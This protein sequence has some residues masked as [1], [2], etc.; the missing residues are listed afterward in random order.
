MATIKSI[1][2]KNFKVLR[3]CELPLSQFTLIIGPNGSGKST[4][5]ESV[6]A[7]LSKLDWDS[8]VAAGVR[9]QRDQCIEVVQEWG[10]LRDSVI[11]GRRWSANGEDHPISADTGGPNGVPRTRLEDKLARTRVFALDP[12]CLYQNVQLAPDQELEAD[13]TRLAGVVDRLRD[14]APDRFRL[15]NEEL[16]RWIP[17]FDHVLFSTPYPGK[18]CLALRTTVGHHKITAGDLSQGTLLALAI[19]TIASLADPPPILGLE[20]PNRGLHPRLLRD[21]RDAMYRLAYPDQYGDK[22]E[23]VQVIATTHSPYMVDLFRD[24]PEEIVI[25]QRVGDNVKFER[26]SDRPN[27]EE[28]IQDARL[29]DLWYT[30]VLGGVPAEP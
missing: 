14:E 20:E 4:A 9:G 28:I 18:R 16:H 21:V 11:L 22:R 25:A 17:E 3:D 29:G 5:L 30:G 6:K 13:G 1:R 24:H 7:I 23:P 15:L 12:R 26:L 10:G 19:L 2:F 8:M 27:V